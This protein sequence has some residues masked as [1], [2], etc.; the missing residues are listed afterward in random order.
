MGKDHDRKKWRRWRQ[1]RGQR[2][3]YMEEMISCWI[4]TGLSHNG[5]WVKEG[6]VEFQQVFPIMVAGLMRGRLNF[7][8]PFS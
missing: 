1:R 2:K 4:S 3:G 5:H 8:R 6:K 7:N